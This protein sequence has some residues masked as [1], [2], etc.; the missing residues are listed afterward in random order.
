MLTAQ[1]PFPDSPGAPTAGGG[2]GDE[3]GQGGL[4]R[5][6]AG[7]DRLVRADYLPLPPQLAAGHPA[8]DQVGATAAHAA[9]VD[10]PPAGWP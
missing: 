2:G 4:P 3:D 5:K 8:C 6:L 9:N 7:Y 10:Y 1:C